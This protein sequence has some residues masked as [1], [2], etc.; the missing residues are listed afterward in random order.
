MGKGGVQKQSYW[1][2]RRQWTGS[3]ILRVTGCKFYKKLKSDLPKWH[4]YSSKEC[5]NFNSLAL[6]HLAFMKISS[7]LVYWL[8]IP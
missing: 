1:W 3:F 8:C 6:R 7:Q 2:L 5:L 4:Y